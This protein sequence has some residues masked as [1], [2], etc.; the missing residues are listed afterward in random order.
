MADFEKEPEKGQEQEFNDLESFGESKIEEYSGLK[1][2]LGPDEEIEMMSTALLKEEDKSIVCL[3]DRR[4]LI[5]NS[6]KSKLLGKRNRFEDMKLGQIKDIKVEERKDFDVLRIE[7]ESEEREIMTPE[8]K[9]VEISGMIREQ[10]EKDERDPAEQLEKIGKERDKGN[11][12]EEE[13]R[14]KK[15][16]LMDRI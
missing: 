5:F 2:R 8:G 16:E 11:I 14:E 9:G 7:T 10:Q 6:D 13:Y 15:D 4:L 1:E 12:S 3:T